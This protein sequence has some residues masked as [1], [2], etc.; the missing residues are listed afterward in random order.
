MIVQSKAM[1]LYHLKSHHRATRYL[2]TVYFALL[3]NRFITFF[4]PTTAKNDLPPAVKEAVNKIDEINGLL[5]D[6]SS[7]DEQDG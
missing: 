7:L 6:A 3:E 2:C 5:M 4:N 1:Q